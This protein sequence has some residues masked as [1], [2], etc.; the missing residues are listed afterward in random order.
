M[1]E[2]CSL[3]FLMVYLRANYRTKNGARLVH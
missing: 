3:G 1:W 2:T